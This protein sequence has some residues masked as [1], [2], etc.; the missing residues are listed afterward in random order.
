MDFFTTTYTAY[1]GSSY[2]LC[3]VDDLTTDTTVTAAFALCSTRLLFP[4]DIIAPLNTVTRK[5]VLALAE[6]Y[7]GISL[8]AREPSD[9]WVIAG[10]AS[11][12]TDVFMKQLSGN[13]EYRF[14]QKQAA[15]RV[16]ELD[17]ERP[18]LYNLGSLLHLDPSEGDF[19]TLKAGIVL[20]ILDRR[21]TK[22]S[23]S[24][25]VGRIIGR[26]LTNSK[27]ADVDSTLI[28]TA[29]FQRQCEKMGHIKLDTFFQQWVYGAG[30]P[31]FLVTQRFNKKKLVVE[32][33]IKQ[34]QAEREATA[35][36]LTPET[37][38]RDVKED[39]N[40]VYAGLVQPVFTVI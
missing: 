13:N 33:L 8:I 16:Y 30:C 35:H 2:K 3:F 31:M 18:S 29:Q 37:F 12:M 27:A 17:M 1:S 36:D 34:T 10:M 9:A 4:E 20:F 23:G 22:S 38:M 25:G 21:L 11:F 40:E 24:A 39:M 26:I 19:L 14:Q 32:M 5:L 15:D 7:A 6:Q 28:S